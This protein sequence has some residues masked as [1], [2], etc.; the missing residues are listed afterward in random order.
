VGGGITGFGA[1]IFI[2]DDPVKGHED[3]ESPVIRE[4]AWQWYIGDVY[5]RLETHLASGQRAAVAVIQTRWNDDDLA[6]RILDESNEQWTVLDLPAIDGA[7]NALWPEKYTITE[8]QH[9]QQTIGAR[10]WNALYQQRPVPDEGEFFKQ[11]WFQHYDRA[12]GNIRTYAASDYAVTADGGDYTCHLVVGLDEGGDIY[13]LDLWRAQSEPD[14]WIEVQLDLVKLWEP[15]FW[16][17]EK[18]QI[19]KAIGPF[20]RKRMSERGRWQAFQEFTSATD[21]PTRARSFQ[22]RMASGRVHF[23][24]Q[25]PWLGELMNEMLRFPHG[26][27]DDQVDTLS[28]IGRMLDSLISA[29]APEQK[30]DPYADMLKPQSFAEQVGEHIK[31][32]RLESKYARI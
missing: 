32:Q 27:H 19:A 15:L 14:A 25:A 30:V 24:K 6:G 8:L 17:V 20:L 12:P 29:R 18:G 10:N 26:R 16:A 7:G 3:A 31:Q 22:A 13:V 4:T 23:P 1:N 21:K 2:I 11:E 28:L 9:I 5:S